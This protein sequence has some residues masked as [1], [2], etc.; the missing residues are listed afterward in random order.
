M[1]VEHDPSLE[2]LA[3]E[4]FEL[5]ILSWRARAMARSR[6]SPDLSENEFITLDL[7][8]RSEPRT[9]GELQRS[10]GVLPAQMSRIMRS[11]E[12]KYGSPLIDCKINTSDKRRIDVR[13]T[14]SGCS[15]YDAFRAARLA[16]SVAVL[17][18]LH[19]PD[20]LEFMRILRVIRKQLAKQLQESHLENI[21]QIET[22]A[23][24]AC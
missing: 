1:N 15:A 4:I 17:E 19:E 23:D 11:L 24:Q 14:D 5:T 7:L 8:K 21:S 12:S 13:L 2:T 16:V 20:R 3:D 22:K 10:I 18:H 6:P 9:V